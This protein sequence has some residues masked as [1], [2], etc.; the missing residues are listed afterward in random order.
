MLVCTAHV[1]GCDGLGDAVIPRPGL[2]ESFYVKRRLN[3]NRQQNL[4][5]GTDC[6]QV[7]RPGNKSI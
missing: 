4:E 5:I 1:Y 7:L 6:H 3:E 2:T